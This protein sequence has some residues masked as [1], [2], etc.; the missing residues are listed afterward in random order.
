M[1]QLLFCLLLLAARPCAA[2]S[3]R[4]EAEDATLVGVMVTNAC[5]GFSGRGYVSGMEHRTSKIVFSFDAAAGLYDL[6]IRYSSPFGNK[7]FVLNLNGAKLSGQFQA[8]TNVFATHRAGLVELPG[9]RNRLAIEYGWGYYDVDYLELT[10]MAKSEA[11]A[12]PSAALSD[13]AAAPA[14]RALMERLI[15]HYGTG[16]FSGVQSAVDFDYVRETTG[17]TPAI[18]GMDLMDY[19][20]SRIEHGAKPRGLPEKAI[21]KAHQGCMVTVMWHWNAPEGLGRVSTNETG[22]ATEARWWTGFYTSATT[23]SLK[24]ALA[25]PSS[26]NYSFIIRDIDAIAVQLRKF[27]DAG[28]PVLWRPLHEADGGHFWWGGDG[29][30]SFVQLWRL[31]HQRLVEHH[32]LH[33]LVWVFTGPVDPKWYPGD[34]CVDV[35]GLDAYPADR[36]DP[37]VSDWMALSGR[38]GGK[39]LIALTE[40][41]GVPDVERMQRLGVWWSY[42]VSW[43]GARGPRRAAEEDLERIY[44]SPGVLNGPPPQGAPQ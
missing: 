36:H 16:T 33:N 20:P 26:T 6:A 15:S 41:G 25:D 34:D 1:K 3:L 12:K 43:T 9:G 7:G 17:Q 5:A 39:K 4:L 21:D 14:A 10:P 24:Q 32:G 13:P 23:F 44:R 2:E 31:L 30:E 42:F 40:F 38:F 11:P 27:A 35:V 37:L 8:T 28:V 22:K 18:F 19:S 29:P